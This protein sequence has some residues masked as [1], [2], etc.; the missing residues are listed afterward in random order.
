MDFG[1]L[2]ASGLSSLR[3]EAEK[4]KC[5]EIRECGCAPIGGWVARLIKRWPSPALIS[6]GLDP[7][8]M[9]GDGAR[10]ELM[11]YRLN[12][13]AIQITGRS[14]LD[15]LADLLTSNGYGTRKA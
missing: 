10:P 9:D 7:D 3:E 6:E 15:A 5:A 1:D 8:E 2:L 13:R 12:K 14:D 4:H 11:I